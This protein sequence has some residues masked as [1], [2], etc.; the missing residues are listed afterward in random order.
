MI[1]LLKN[2]RDAF[3]LQ[4]LLIF[5]Q[6]KYWHIAFALQKA[7]AK[8]SHIFFNKKYWHIAFALQKLLT[9]FQ[10]KKK[11]KNGEFQI[12]TFVMLMKH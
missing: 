10:Q 5:F 9:F 1:F 7:K 12:L 3:A 11:K 4:K 8:A 2:E 6:Q